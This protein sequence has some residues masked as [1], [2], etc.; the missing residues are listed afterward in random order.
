MELLQKGNDPTELQKKD[1]AKDLNRLMAAA[2]LYDETRFADVELRSETESLLERVLQKEEERPY[3]GRFLL[4]DAYPNELSRDRKHADEATALQGK[5]P[6]DRV[7]VVGGSVKMQ[8]D[9]T[10]PIQWLMR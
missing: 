1:L 3:L 4:E 2:D 9:A 8:H 5:L 7:L 6:A 10:E